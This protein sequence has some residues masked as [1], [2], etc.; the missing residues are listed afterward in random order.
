MIF[1]ESIAADW[2]SGF[3]SALMAHRLALGWQRA[4]DRRMGCAG[5]AGDNKILR[6]VREIG[7]HY[8]A[9]NDALAGVG[10]AHAMARRMAGPAERRTGVAT[11]SRGVPRIVA[12]FEQMGPR[13]DRARMDTEHAADG[14]SDRA[15]EKGEQP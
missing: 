15:S 10:H 6:P 7:V 2:R 9:V 13:L 1:A 5:T 12:A 11:T 4:E 14:G 3:V 8:R